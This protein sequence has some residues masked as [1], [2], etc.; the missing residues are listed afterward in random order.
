MK[1]LKIDSGR[2]LKY[3]KYF[4]WF[5]L[6]VGVAIIAGGIYEVRQNGSWEDWNLLVQGTFFIIWGILEIN[7][8]LND[9]VT[10]LRVN[11]KGIEQV[12]SWGEEQSIQWNKINSI[13]LD[14]HEIKYQSQDSDQPDQLKLPNYSYKQFQQLKKKIEE[15]AEIHQLAYEII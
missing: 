13:K 4:G 7:G 10:G 14:L 3:K 11:K 9:P 8:R 1:P 2:R 12:R 6:A 15:A 5:A